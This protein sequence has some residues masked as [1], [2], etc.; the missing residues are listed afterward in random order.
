MGYET[1]EG[2]NASYFLIFA[3]SSI[4]FSSLHLLFMDLKII[5]WNYRGLSNPHIVDRI[6]NF[7]KNQKPDFICLVGTKSIAPRIHHFY[8]KLK[9]C[10]EWAAILSNG[11]SSGIIVL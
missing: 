5:S 1:E 9:H 2:E 3:L 11:F 4:F 7:M 8:A 10:W 6:K